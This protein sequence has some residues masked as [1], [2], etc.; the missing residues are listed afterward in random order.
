ML[1]GFANDTKAF[2]LTLEVVVAPEEL[3][4]ISLDCERP[5][6]DPSRLTEATIC[7]PS[8][9]QGTS[10]TMLDETYSADLYR[11]GKTLA[12]TVRFGKM[13]PWTVQL[14]NQSYP[15]CER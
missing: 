2:F 14:R 6:S 3:R 9:D 7:G 5:A 4:V 8:V 11:A 1:R 15:R 13:G 10:F 12:V